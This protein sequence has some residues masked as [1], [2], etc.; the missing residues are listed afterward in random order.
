LPELGR[1]LI[2]R[3]LF[4]EIA[5]EQGGPDVGDAGLVIE[6]AARELERP[7]VDIGGEDAEAPLLAPLEELFLDEDGD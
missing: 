6:A 3:P 2:A 5:L 1:H 7:S 4:I